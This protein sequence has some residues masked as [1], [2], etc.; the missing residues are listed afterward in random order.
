[1]NVALFTRALV[2]D[3]PCYSERIAVVH[4]NLSVRVLEDHRSRAIGIEQVRLLTCLRTRRT[5][6]LHNREG[7]SSGG[8]IISSLC[9][10]QPVRWDFGS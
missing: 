9:A 6:D 7:A 10:T 2:V 3:R 1:M 4:R 5:K 8:V